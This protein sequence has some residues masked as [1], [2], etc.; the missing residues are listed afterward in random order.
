MIEEKFHA[1]LETIPSELDKMTEL[2][3]QPT[4]KRPS[5]QR[6]FIEA[7]IEW[8]AVKS[9]SFCS[10]TL[11]LF[12]EMVQRANPDFSV[13]VYNTPKHHFKRLTEI[14][15]QLPDCQKKSY[16]STRQKNSTDVFWRS[17]C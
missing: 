9:I 13:P 8:I 16:C 4:Q 14:R 5:N 2:V 12:Q 17:L 11:P 1:K 7:L 15:R 3:K 10:V 6:A